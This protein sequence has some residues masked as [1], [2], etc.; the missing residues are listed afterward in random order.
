MKNLKVG[1]IFSETIT[2]NHFIEIDDKIRKEND[3]N[4]A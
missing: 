1:I 4:S 2:A 3:N